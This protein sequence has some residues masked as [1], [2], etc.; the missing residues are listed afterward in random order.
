MRITQFKQCFILRVLIPFENNYSQG[1]VSA[2]TLVF[3]KPFSKKDIKYSYSMER[4][5]WNPVEHLLGSFFTKRPPSPPAYFFNRK[6]LRTPRSYRT[7]SFINFL[8]FS[9]E[10][11]IFVTRFEISKLFVKCK[12]CFSFRIYI[13]VCFECYC[14]ER[15]IM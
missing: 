4:R 7:P 1:W 6:N 12:Q 2:V 10:N 3:V 5:I 14:Q 13:V 11:N 8:V 15:R 9:E